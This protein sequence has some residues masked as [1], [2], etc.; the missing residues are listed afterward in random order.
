MR[1]QVGKISARVTAFV[2]VGIAL[3][4]ALGAQTSPPPIVEFPIPT[5]ASAPV[6]I[7]SGLD[8]NMW[9]TE[10]AGHKIGRITSGG[11]ITEF[12]VS[13]NP[14][15]I[16]AGLDGNLWFTAFSAS[17]GVGY[18]GRITLTGAVNTFDCSCSFPDG[19]TSGPDGNMW[20]GYQQGIG[21]VTPTGIFT[22]FAMEGTVS[23]IAAGSD[24]NMWF[25]YV[26][27]PA[28]KFPK[29][30]V[31]RITLAGATTFFELPGN[32]FAFPVSITNGPD[33]NLWFIRGGVNRITIDG[34]L[35]EFPYPGIVGEMPNG[36]ETVDAEQ[37]VAGPDGK[38][39]FTRGASVGRM[40]PNGG[41]FV[42]FPSPTAEALCG[43]GP[44]P[45]LSGI[46][47]GPDGNL[48]F[49]ERVGNQIGR[50]TATV[51]LVGN[52]NLI[53]RCVLDELLHPVLGCGSE[54]G[55]VSVWSLGGASI[56]A[57]APLSRGVPLEWDVA[58]IGDLDG[59]GTADLV[60]RDSQRGDVAAWLMTDVRVTDIPVIAAA[61]SLDWQIAGLGDLNGDVNA[62]IVWRNVE[63]G[64][65]AVWLMNGASV[66]AIPVISSGVPSAWQIAATGD[67]NGDGRDDLIWHHT[68]NGAVAVWLMNREIVTQSLVVAPS[69]P[70]DWHLA[71][72]GDLDGDGNSDL[73]WRHTQTGD[74]AGWLLNGATKIQ[75]PVIAPGVP[76]TW[77]IVKVVDVDED[78]KADLL[79]RRDTPLST[80]PTLNGAV[81]AWLMNGTSVRQSVTLDRYTQTIQLTPGGLEAPQWEIQ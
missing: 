57:Q 71:G 58:A 44:C 9:F 23:G 39:W 72:T 29:P 42:E 34:A 15:Q 63:T 69:V 30:K 25:G 46:A 8:G 79:W 52:T 41:E 10:S 64:D 61:V 35:T 55:T 50:I 73:V 68:H 81:V 74:V 75:E 4:S 38:L 60:W 62:D 40:N 19:I 45:R 3:S 33:G 26:Q 16:A 1:H 17:N 53:W 80:E 36:N 37:I 77:T 76:L 49:T 13:G 67:V 47:P 27:A 70:L 6:S 54:T 2:L 22:H 20:F 59:N 11:S 43:G 21:R 56:R 5:S 18:I 14:R 51:D 65:V 78:G 31:G 32:P 66:T 12:L 48:W 7:T 28:T 24:G